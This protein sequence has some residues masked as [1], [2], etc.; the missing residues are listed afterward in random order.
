M[1]RGL[2]GYW[3][4]RSLTRR[5]R[6][7]VLMILIILVLIVLRLLIELSWSTWDTISSI[8]SILWSFYHWWQLKL[9]VVWVITF[10]SCVSFSISNNFFAEDYLMYLSLICWALVTICNC[11]PN[12]GIITLHHVNLVERC[13]NHV[14]GV[15]SSF[16]IHVELVKMIWSMNNWMP[17]VCTLLLV[18]VEI[19]VA[20]IKTIS[21]FSSAIVEL[22]I[23]RGWYTIKWA[24][25]WPN[26]NLR[27]SRVV[28]SSTTCLS[29]SLI[30][31]IKWV[32][33]HMWCSHA[34]LVIQRWCRCRAIH[35]ATTI[36]L[37]A[38]G[39]W[40]PL[41]LLAIWASSWSS[42]AIDTIYLLLL[43]C[44]LQLLIGIWR[45]TSITQ[46]QKLLSLV[47]WTAPGVAVRHAHK[48]GVSRS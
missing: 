3:V 32:V 25:V 12:R 35:L 44:I 22:I 14:S 31:S 26:G 2:R 29:I 41:I 39:P 19:V 4:W 40:L 7:H 46:W 10:F 38:D 9:L 37:T 30:T 34:I 36:H 20:T 18:W 33:S 5:Q 42:M 13:A 45:D 8:C 47:C 27:S 11:R 28:L 1:G 16:T 48:H 24:I 21:A 43:N 17:G 23:R 15:T 6:Q